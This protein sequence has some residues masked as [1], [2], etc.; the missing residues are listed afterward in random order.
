MQ[1]F[2]GKMSLY[3]ACGLHSGS[4]HILLGWN[5]IHFGYPLQIIQVAAGRKKWGW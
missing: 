3:N 2:E 5:V 4:Q 1:V